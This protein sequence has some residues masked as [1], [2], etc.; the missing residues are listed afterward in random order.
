MRVQLMQYADTGFKIDDLNDG[1]DASTIFLYPQ[2]AT[3][4]PANAYDMSAAGR[5]QP[6]P[7]YGV[8]CAKQLAAGG[9][10]CALDL[11]LPAPSEGAIGNRV[12]YLNLSTLYN[13]AH[14]Q[15]KLLA[16]GTSPVSING[17]QPIVDSTARANDV[18]RRV[19]SRVEMASDFPYPEA[20]V[21]VSGSLCKNFV[22]T[23]DPKVAE[24]TA[25]TCKP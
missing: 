7:P 4:P 8:Y 1:S 23:D 5:G 19:E 9:Y 2:G 17:E 21:D 12:A 24:S 10:A 22:V 18:F 11:K 14:F 20:A 6:T 13:P 25:T 16:N 3:T 15:I